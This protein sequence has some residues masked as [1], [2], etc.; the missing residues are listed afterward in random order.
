MKHTALCR[1]LSQDTVVEVRVEQGIPFVGRSG[2][3]HPI[4][5]VCLRGNQNERTRSFRF[6]TFREYHE[7]EVVPSPFKP[8][9]K[10]LSPD[11]MDGGT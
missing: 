6:N 10:V 11:H 4:Y 3:Q 7:G 5:I 2:K 9:N 1:G 8:T